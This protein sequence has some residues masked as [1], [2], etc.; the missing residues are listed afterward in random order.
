M[1]YCSIAIILIIILVLLILCCHHCF[2]TKINIDHFTDMNQKLGYAD[3]QENYHKPL[4]IENILSKNQ[5]QQL[6]DYA[7]DKLVESEIVGGNNKAIRNSMQCWISK[8]NP[9]ILDFVNQ[10][11]EMVDI[12]F[13]NAEDLQIVR[14]L[15]GQYYNEHHDS[16]CDED[17]KCYQFTKRGGQRKLTVLIYLNNNF[18]GGYTLFKNLGI[19]IRGNI[20]DAI[21][22]YP[23]SADSNKCHPLALH[24]GTSVTQGEKWI[25][26]L[27]YRERAFGV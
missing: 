24:A 25:A 5:C 16:C 20:G 13:D 7:K 14:Y 19:Q 12:P 27:W 9:L 4:I 2:R 22:F 8:Y 11:S 26:N 3:I 21:I 1:N 18:E 23:L 17:S 10:I 15:P 6:I